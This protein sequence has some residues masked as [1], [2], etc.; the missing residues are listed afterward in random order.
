M[1]VSTKLTRIARFLL[2]ADDERVGVFV[3]EP[4]EATSG[5]YVIV[6]TLWCDEVKTTGTGK[7]RAER[8]AFVR[9][10]AELGEA[11]VARRERFKDRDGI[12]GGLFRKRAVE[13]A[14]CEAIERDAFLYHYRGRRPFLAREDLARDLVAFVMASALPTIHAV[15]V[16]DRGS[17]EGR[18]ECLTIGLGAHRD[19]AESIEKAVGEASTMR[20][21]HRLRPGWCADIYGGVEKPARL[22]DFHHAQSRDPRNR[23]I[24]AD[25]CAQ[26]GSQR[27]SRSPLLHGDW[28]IQRLK[29]PVRFLSFVR[30]KN[31]ELAPLEFGRPEPESTSPPLYHPIW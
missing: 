27:G 17:A 29:S 8:D 12:A 23:E 18:S 26:T 14:C 5:L 20:L 13:R 6:T 15:L 28:R 22:P 31:P 1:G 10:V 11:L 9:S 25:L 24:F 16:T 7:A 21:D 4:S 2:R 30:V 19:R 3:H